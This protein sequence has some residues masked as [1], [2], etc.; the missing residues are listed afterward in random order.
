LSFACRSL[1]RSL[2]LAGKRAV[3]SL[4]KV[5]VH[6]YACFSPSRACL[7]I[8]ATIRYAYVV[9]FFVAVPLSMFYDNC[10]FT[11]S[12]SL[13][14]HSLTCFFFSS[15]SSGL[16]V[17][18]SSSVGFQTFILPFFSGF[19]IARINSLRLVGY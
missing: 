19:C 3:D 14:C 16:R 8:L 12:T 4:G 15:H 13:E 6:L 7:K 17:A 18:T 5:E 1:A 11:I 2:L 9:P 10:P